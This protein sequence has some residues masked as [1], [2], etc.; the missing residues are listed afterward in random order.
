MGGSDDETGEFLSPDSGSPMNESGSADDETSEF[1]PETAVPEKKEPQSTSKAL[2]QHVVVQCPNC[3]NTFQSQQKE[4]EGPEITCSKCG[5]KFE[6]TDVTAFRAL[7]M[8]RTVGSP[9][10]EEMETSSERTRT[11][12]GVVRQGDPYIGR[13]LGGRY[14]INKRI[15]SGG[16]ATVYDATRQ[17]LDV[18]QPVAVKILHLGLALGDDTLRRFHNEVKTIVSLQHPN[19]VHI[20]DFEQEDETTIY[21]A[22]ER[23]FGRS[24][25]ENMR[26]EN[27]DMNPKRIINIMVQ[28]CSVLSAAHGM[29]IVHR[30]VTPG[31]IMLVEAV[32]GRSEMVKVLDFGIAKFQSQEATL[33]QGGVGTPPYMAPEQW[34]GEGDHRLD[35]YALGVVLYE[36]IAGHPPFQGNAAS[37]MMQH[38][39][40][41][42][43]EIPAEVFNEKPGLIPLKDIALRCLQKKP[44]D[45]YASAEEMSE[46]LQLVQRSLNNPELL[47]EGLSA[48][49]EQ[50]GLPAAPV[51]KHRKGKKGVYVILAVLVVAVV[52]LGLVLVTQKPEPGT[53][54]GGVA[55]GSNIPST[56]PGGAPARPSPP[57]MNTE[58]VQAF[59]VFEEQLK[60][61]GQAADGSDY[62]TALGNLKEAD[63]QLS[64]VREEIVADKVKDLG[65]EATRN[66]ILQ[67]LLS[68]AAEL[69]GTS[70]WEDADRLYELVRSYP[71]ASETLQESAR[72]NQF[73]LRFRKGE[74]EFRRNKFDEAAASWQQAQVLAKSPRESERIA[75][76]MK[77][78]EKRREEMNSTKREVEWAQAL[79]TDFGQLSKENKF[80]ELRDMLQ[81]ASD[82]APSADLKTWLASASNVMQML[83]IEKT[84]GLDAALPKPMATRPATAEA[85]RALRDVED[86][87]RRWTRAYPE[88]LQQLEKAKKDA[89]EFRWDDA[90]RSVNDARSVGTR[91]GVT[92]TQSLNNRIDVLENKVKS[93]KDTFDGLR[94][95]SETLT[96]ETLA[97]KMDPALL[98]QQAAT[99]RA[100]TELAQKT[101]GVETPQLIATADKIINYNTGVQAL[102]SWD[103]PTGT[104]ALVKAGDFADA[105][106]L[107]ACAK[108]LEKGN[109]AEFARRVV[110]KRLELKCDGI[111]I[112]CQGLSEAMNSW[113][114]YEKALSDGDLNRLEVL[115]AG[116]PEERRNEHIRTWQKLF[117]YYPK[118]SFKGQVADLS[119]AKTG[120]FRMKISG[121]LILPDY[122]GNPLAQRNDGQTDFYMSLRE[123]GGK[124]KVVDISVEAP[125]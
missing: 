17:M 124:W 36:T 51:F 79:Q 103:F 18:E 24:L 78:I 20:Y 67:G 110:E 80:V 104:D 95:R 1:G 77:S 30:D 11:I 122:A 48:I 5:T 49:R 7:E 119:R 6:P 34:M 101:H 82:E 56:G 45:R 112:A 81:K 69:G 109:G 8:T 37:L 62:P 19:A 32:E 16:W 76:G 99:L 3:G 31:N 108:G 113:A 117:M 106:Q 114:D 68:Q 28:V 84:E 100:E 88:V 4:G 39:K 50:E 46:D 47:A 85:D 125:G 94:A 27:A 43:P 58:E 22:M 65:L 9:V 98:S 23:I 102:M 107:V 44:E 90:L 59:S 60:A 26:D 123:E 61:A 2:T 72:L 55:G 97:G 73:D 35:L 71:K 93:A 54:P 89:G 115:V 33:T 70:K 118:L 13:T 41:D 25:K 75:E 120:E 83:A 10:T 21:I 57:K 14:K 121:K 63:Q 40:E 96:R 29:G 38:I 87:L 74:D 111:I 86:W 105:A 92:L 42:P 52:G 116:M 15:A 64:K 66:R 12:G 53:V 91:S